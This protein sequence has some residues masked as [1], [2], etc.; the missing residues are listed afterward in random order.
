ME[1]DKQ[2][3]ESFDR[4]EELKSI[5]T[6]QRKDFLRKFTHEQLLDYASHQDVKRF[7]LDIYTKRTSSLGADAGGM[8]KNERAIYSK[9]F[10]PMAIINLY[11]RDENITEKSLKKELD[12][13]PGSKDIKGRDMF[14]QNSLRTN[15]AKFNEDTEKWLSANKQRD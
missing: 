9:K 2:R 12:T 10:V 6:R 8:K 15:L 7:L 13:F 4:F 14:T 5:V 1:N 11:S 3:K